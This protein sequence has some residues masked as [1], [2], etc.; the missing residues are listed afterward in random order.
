VG[1]VLFHA[2]LVMLR[3][4][5]CHDVNEILA[6]HALRYLVRTILTVFMGDVVKKYPAGDIRENAITRTCHI[7]RQTLDIKNFC[8]WHIQSTATPAAGVYTCTL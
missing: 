1:V 5:K 8:T 2:F 6:F 7:A 4:G 3:T